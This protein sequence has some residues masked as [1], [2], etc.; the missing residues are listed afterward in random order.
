MKTSVTVPSGACDTHMHFYDGAAS[1]KP[2]TP[3]PGNY[4]VPM[5]RELQKSSGS[6]A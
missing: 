4:T 1:A 2:G 6:S 3:N 5:Y